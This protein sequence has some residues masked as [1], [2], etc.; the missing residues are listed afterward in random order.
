MVTR[1][2]LSVTNLDLCVASKA[3]LVMYQ[4]QLS[5]GLGGYW[6]LVLTNS[7]TSNNDYLGREKP[8]CSQVNK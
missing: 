3:Q 2:T 5:I 7:I 1:V 8:R 4:H 6:N